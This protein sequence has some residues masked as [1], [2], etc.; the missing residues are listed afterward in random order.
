MGAGIV[1]TGVGTRVVSA[2]LVGA[3][4]GLGVVGVGKLGKL[5]GASVVG[6]SI[7]AG[8]DICDG[9]GVMGAGGPACMCARARAHVWVCVHASLCTRTRGDG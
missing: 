8:V 3:R 7:G 6:C 5:V 1:G 9:Q 4:V 2:E